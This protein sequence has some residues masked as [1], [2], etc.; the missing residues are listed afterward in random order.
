M[1]VIQWISFRGIGHAQIGTTGNPPLPTVACGR[2]SWPGLIR[3]PKTK[4]TQICR[5]CAAALGLDA[6]APKPEPTSTPTTPRQGSFF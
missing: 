1:E 5:E 4:P 3:Y 2:T 6:A